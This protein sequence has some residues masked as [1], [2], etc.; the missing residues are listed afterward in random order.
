VDKSLAAAIQKETD[1]I[2][3]EMAFSLTVTDPAI[4]KE[5]K[6]QKTINDAQLSIDSVIDDLHLKTAEELIQI[7]AIVKQTGESEIIQYLAGKL[8]SS[9]AKPSD[10]EIDSR[11]SGRDGLRKVLVGMLRGE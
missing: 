7:C 11:W 8:E 2:L 1:K 9:S 6:A 10:I 5:L 3:E 4:I